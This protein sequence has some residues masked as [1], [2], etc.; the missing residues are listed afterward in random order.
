MEVMSIKDMNQITGGTDAQRKIAQDRQRKREAKDKG[1]DPNKSVLAD[2]SKPAEE[3]KDAIQKVADERG[4]KAPTP[5]TKASAAADPLKK[6]ADERGVKAPTPPTRES[7]AKDPLKQAAKKRAEEKAAANKGGAL[8][9]QDRKPAIRKSQIG[10]WAE[11][12][13]KS[14]GALA[15]R[16]AD[17]ITK[18][19]IQK[20]KVKDVTPKP[21][22]KKRETVSNY[23]P[24]TQTPEKEQQAQPDAITKKKKKKGPGIFQRLSNMRRDSDGVGPSS[25]VS[26]SGLQQR[27]NSV[28]S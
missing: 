22:K 6:M 16:A 11:G 18:P 3:K 9:K 5:P 26:H 23:V 2:G 20:V 7:A 17:K 27:G 12:S 13:K 1:F 25:E 8:V 10:K 24:R 15:K 28:S 21:E 14:P 4:V 19:E